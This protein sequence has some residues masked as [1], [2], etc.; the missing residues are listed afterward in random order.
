M[1]LISDKEFYIL[2]Y[3]HANI[4]FQNFAIS[5]RDLALNSYLSYTVWYT[6]A[7]YALLIL[8]FDNDLPFM[9][10]FVLFM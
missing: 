7:I 9:I 6:G 3:Q 8:Y 1:P 5:T 2:K 10:L 4:S